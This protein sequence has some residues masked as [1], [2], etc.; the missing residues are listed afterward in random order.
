MESKPLLLVIGVGEATGQSLSRLAAGRYRLVLVARSGQL[1]ESLA[2]E[3]PDTIAVRGDI[4]D[5]Q[6]WP[7]TLST[8]VDDAGVPA[9]ILINTESAAWGAY[10]ELPLD[11]FSASFEVNATGLLQTVQVLFPDPGLISPGTRVMLSS[12]PAAYSPPAYMLG[13]APS[14]V[15]QRVMAELMDRSIAPDRLRFS[16]FSIDGA[17]DEPKMR[18]MLPDKPDSYFI[19]PDD[20]AA[21]MLR[22]FES[23]DFSLVSGISGESSFANRQ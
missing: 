22:V 4:G 3:L 17:I 2:E 1:I 13:L 8:V 15:A 20:I 11:Q 16:V 14:R 21:E 5:R 12:S 6:S 19:Q 10:N 23:D 9:L 18:A 7:D